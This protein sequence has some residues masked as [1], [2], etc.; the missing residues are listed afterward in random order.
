MWLFESFLFFLHVRPRTSN[1]NEDNF[2]LMYYDAHNLYGWAMSQSLPY[3]KLKWVEEKH[4]EKV[5]LD[6]VISSQKEMDEA[7]VG[8]YFQ[9]DLKYPE[10]LQ[11]KHK[12]LPYAPDKESPIKEWLSDYQQSFNI[13]GK[14]PEKLLTTLNDKE[15]YV[16]HQRNLR[17]FIC[18]VESEKN[19]SNFEI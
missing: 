7:E 14:S 4:N 18:W 13:K 6:I 15:S 12:D 10:E 3:G 17:I 16:L 9:V 1:K 8:Y 2:Y 19:S 11:N 5:L